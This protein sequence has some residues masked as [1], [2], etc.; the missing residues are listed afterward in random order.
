MADIEA[1]EMTALFRNG[2][3]NWRVSTRALDTDPYRG[4][5]TDKRLDLARPLIWIENGSIECLHWR[6]RSIRVN[7]EQEGVALGGVVPRPLA[8]AIS[9]EPR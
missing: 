1:E 7:F 6:A 4:L 3:A 5:Q 9:C 2:Y 8:E